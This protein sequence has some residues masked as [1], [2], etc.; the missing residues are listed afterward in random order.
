M[1]NG[2]ALGDA[3]VCVGKEEHFISK[4]WRGCHEARPNACGRNNEASAA[5]PEHVYQ[6]RVWGS[7]AK[8]AH[9][10]SFG[11]N[12]WGRTIPKINLEDVDRT[13]S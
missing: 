2:Y 10:N 8:P 11:C 7:G 12:G 3:D 1:T 9:G 5:T 6:C 13:P 4:R